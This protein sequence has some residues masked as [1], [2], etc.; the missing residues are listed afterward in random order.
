MKR[1]EGRGEEGKRGRGGF[2]SRGAVGENQLPLIIS[3]LG[4]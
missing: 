4:R 1:E 2:D 3:Y